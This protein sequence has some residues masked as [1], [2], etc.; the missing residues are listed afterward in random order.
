ME[1][2]GF[3]PRW[4]S[5]IKGCFTNARS[6]I[7]VNRSPTMEFDISKGLRQGDPLSPFLFI[8][9][10]EGLHAL[11]CKAINMGIYRGAIIGHDHTRISHLIYA[12]M[13]FLWATGVGVSDDEVLNMAHIIGCGVADFPFKYLGVPVGGNM[14][15]CHNWETVVNKFTSK[16]SLWKTRLLSVG[17]R[18]TLIKLV[19]GNLPTY[20]MSLYFMPVT[21]RSKLESMR[22]KFFIGCEPDSWSWSPDVHNGFSVASAHRLVDSHFLGAAPLATR[23]NKCIPIKANVFLWRAMLNK[24]P[25]RVNL[26]RRGIDVDSLLCLVF[27][28]DVETV[29]H[30]FFSYE[31]AKDL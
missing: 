7:L 15:M 2:I 8:L 28:E 1:K 17:G 18:I 6:S 11:I 13:L 16:L 25:T 23:W 20:F 31:V 24:L 26:D 9:V 14:S 19:L 12:A 30:L 27:H 5:W 29:N 4:R 3:G 10:M 22:L 21:V